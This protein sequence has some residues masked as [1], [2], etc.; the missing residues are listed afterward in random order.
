MPTK[1][2]VVIAVT[3]FIAIAALTGLAIGLYFHFRPSSTHITT[4]VAQTTEGN[5]YAST[6]F[7]YTD[8]NMIGNSTNETFT[9]MFAGL[10]SSQMTRRML[11]AS[12]SVVNADTTLHY[13]HDSG[14]QIKFRNNEVLNISVPID[15]VVSY[16][17]QQDD[18]QGYARLL[19]DLSQYQ[20]ENETMTG[21]DLFDEYR[22]EVLAAIK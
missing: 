6:K 9:I 7:L 22:T 10:N 15:Q 12:E 4:T 14:I 5:S 2:K 20:G 17:A 11:Q 8:N 16:I 21:S 13:T 18:P 19:Q 3:I 1:K